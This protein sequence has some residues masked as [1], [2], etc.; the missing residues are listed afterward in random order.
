MKLLLGKTYKIKYKLLNNLI[1]TSHKSVLDFGCGDCQ[2]Y[3]Y[4]SDKQKYIGCDINKTFVTNAIDRGITAYVADIT[5]FDYSIKFDCVIFSELL[6]YFYP[7]QEKII[8]KLLSITNKR[9]IIVEPNEHLSQHK[10]KFI[11]K[12]CQMINNPGT[13]RPSNFY[14]KTELLNIYKKFNNSQYIDLGRIHIVV[15]DK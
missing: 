12:I 5:N 15:F 1:I 3:D 9:L 4:I 10:N 7:D 8:E 11:R 2:L 14:N 13:G 6:H